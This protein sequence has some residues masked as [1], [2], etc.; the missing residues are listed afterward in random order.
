MDSIVL[1][2]AVRKFWGGSVTPLG[3]DVWYR[4]Y[5]GINCKQ[6]AAFGNNGFLLERG[7][8]F[9]PSDPNIFF[10]VNVKSIVR[11]DLAS[12]NSDIFVF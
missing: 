2:G 10:A 6:L 11:L 4:D 3:C 8:W 7:A 12:G 1:L 9:H 5:K